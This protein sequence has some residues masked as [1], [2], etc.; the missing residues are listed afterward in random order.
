MPPVTLADKIPWLASASKKKRW[1]VGVSGGAD[2]MALLH[3]LIDGGFQ[4]LVVCHLDHGLRARA[5]TDDAKFVRGLAGKLSLECVI[6][7]AEVTARMEGRGESM[8][9][10]ARNARLEFFAD[11][12][13]KLRCRRVLLAHHADDQ[14]LAGSR[15]ESL[16]MA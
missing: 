4:N 5:S 2:S 1:L 12:A 11:C 7:R 8:E 16:T 9:T 14:V 3:L 10:A 13:R 15:C 6:D